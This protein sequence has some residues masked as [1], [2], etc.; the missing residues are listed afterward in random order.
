L[1]SERAYLL[2]REALLGLDQLFQVLVQK[3]RP[4]SSGYSSS[5]VDGLSYCV[6]EDLGCC[7]ASCPPL[8][9]S[10]HASHAGKD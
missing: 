1:Y 2:N 7:S 9:E 3:W 10:N 5:L 8:S 6:D 4:S